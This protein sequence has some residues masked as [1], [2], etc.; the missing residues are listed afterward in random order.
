MF[1]THFWTR[2][3]ILLKIQRR[4]DR[5]TVCQVHDRALVVQ[6]YSYD[7]HIWTV[8]CSSR[9]LQKDVCK[10]VVQVVVFIVC[11]FTGYV[12]CS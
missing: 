11:T 3:F 7:V 9:S 12:N 5:V 1:S 10:T 4:R 6:V 8:F 2:C